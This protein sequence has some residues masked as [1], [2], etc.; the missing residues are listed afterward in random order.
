MARMALPAPALRTAR[1]RLRP[2]DDGDADDLFAL[3]ASARVLR[4]RD[5]PPWGGRARAG[6]FITAWRQMAREGTGA[7]LA[8]DRACGGAFTGWCSL[9]RWNPGYRS[10]ALGYRLDAAA[11]GHGYATE[12]AIAVRDWFGAAR[13]VSLIAPGNIRSQAVARRL[14]A[15]PGET[16]ADFEESGPHVVWEHP[17]PAAPGSAR[18]ARPII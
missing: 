14:G 1:L 10:A 11:R 16:I 18:R 3:H 8:V 12:A 2:F 9:N 6:H 7:R 4:Y 17:P 13:Y 5:A 15:V